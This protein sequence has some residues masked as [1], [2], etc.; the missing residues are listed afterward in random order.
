M[1]AERKTGIFH[2]IFANFA[3]ILIF[4]AVI[5]TAASAGF[6]YAAPAASARSEKAP[7]FNLKVLNPGISGYKDF[8]P[9]AFKGRV[10]II[11]FWTTWC[12]HCRSEMP[13]LAKFYEAERGKGVVVL[14]INVNDNLDG[15]RSFV[16]FY[17]IP[18]PVVYGTSR[19]ISDYGGVNEIPQTFFIAKNGDLAFR[20]VGGIT[21]GVLK[22]VT[23]KLLSMP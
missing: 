15:V 20:W 4:S 16:R 17:K 21:V 12:P 3:F 10:V 18:Y 1:A 5:I 8:S 14:G 19:V 13:L 11:N 22:G 2:T 7:D 6:F 9:S 23:D